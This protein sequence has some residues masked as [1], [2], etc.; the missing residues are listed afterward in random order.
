MDTL[1][2]EARCKAEGQRLVRLLLAE[3][4]SR[5][6]SIRSLERKVGVGDSVFAKVLS[7]KVTVQLRHILLM[8]DGLGL[9]WGDFFALAYPEGVEKADEELDQKIHRYLVRVG[10]LHEEALAAQAAASADEH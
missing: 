7:G 5:E 3:A 10:L 2:D 1:P 6:I 9:E 4:R 8:C